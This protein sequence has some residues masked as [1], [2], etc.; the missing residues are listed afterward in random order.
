M[1]VSNAKG[2]KQRDWIFMIFKIFK[3]KGKVFLSQAL[4]AYRGS[5]G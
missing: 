3:V 4:K 5:S 2:L 1:S